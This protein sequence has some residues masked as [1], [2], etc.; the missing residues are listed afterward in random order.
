MSIT[1]TIYGRLPP[2]LQHIACSAAGFQIQRKRYRSDFGRLYLKVCAQQSL[3]GE[4]LRDFQKR[5]LRAHLHAAADTDFWPKIFQDAGVNPGADD[6]FAELEKLP[7]LLKS[8]VRENPSALLN[9]NFE[10]SPLRTVKTSGTTGAGLAFA[11]TFESEMLRWATWWRYRALHG[12]QRNTWCAYFGGQAVVPIYSTRHPFWRW[13]WPGR[14]LM[15]SSYHLKPEN[16]SAYLNAL[17]KYRPPWIHGYP[18]VL[19]LLANLIIAHDEAPLDFVEVV[20]IGSESLLPHQKEAMRRAFGAPVREHYGLAE[21]VANISETPVG[22]LVID[23]DYA[24]VELVPFDDDS[25]GVYRLIGTNFTNPAF[26]LL[27]YD[28]GDIV[29][30]DPTFPQNS[31]GWRIIQSIDGRKEDYITLPDGRRLGRLARIFTDLTTIAEAQIY[32]PHQNRIELR[33]VPGP[34]YRKPKDEPLLLQKAR[35]RMGDEIEITVK[36]QTSIQRTA[37]GKLRFVVSDIDGA[38][39]SAPSQDS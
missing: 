21:S 19:A 29:Y 25:P 10:K 38:Q 30:C 24:F 26:P 14:Q 20:T 37:R 22:E 16:I 7:I 39:I 15:F 17:R 11:E 8:Q 28:T 23:E 27:R 5:R 12:I 18:S 35:R 1:E 31:Q 33:V 32:Q 3:H 6:P 36:Y 13:N 4:D 34:Q 2:L 9:H